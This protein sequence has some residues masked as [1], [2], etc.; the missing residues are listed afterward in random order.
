MDKINFTELNKTDFDLLKNNL[1]SYLNLTNLQTYFPILLHYLE[2]EGDL[3]NNVLKN[4][5]IIN[6]INTIKNDII[7]DYEFNNESNI[8][9]NKKDPYIKTFV[10]AELL[11]QH[12]NNKV[13]RNVFIKITPIIDIIP[14][15]LDEY[16]VNHSVLLP[17]MYQNNLN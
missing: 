16:D 6:T 12:T 11:N 9:I 17:N 10:E 7:E 8:Q 15:I 14:Y 2:E 5:F 4:K 1:Q 13:T 3:H